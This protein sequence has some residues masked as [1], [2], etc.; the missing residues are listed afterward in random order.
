VIRDKRRLDPKTGQRRT[1]PDSDGAFGTPAPAGSRPG[2]G[3][4]ALADLEKQLQERTE[5][6][7]RLQA[8]Y[9]N[10][11]RRVDRDRELAR[12]ATVGSVLSQLLP[13]LDDI[14]RAREHDELTGGFRAVA[15]SLERTVSGLGLEEYGKQGE[16]FDPYLHEALTHM[17]SDDVTEPTCVAVMQLGYRLGDRI[18]RPARVAVAEP[19][20][21]SAPAPEQGDEAA[22]DSTDT[23][24]PAETPDQA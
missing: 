7:Q 11:K 2:P 19:A 15:E 5:D 20:H 22:A 1:P 12:A 4:D 16:P 6:L 17:Y 13:V 10:Y 21:Q 23:T 14:D 9:V 24:E 18:L 3:P 8:E